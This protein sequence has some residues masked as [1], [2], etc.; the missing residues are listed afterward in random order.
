LA[1]FLAKAY[2]RQKGH[3]YAMFVRF[4][5]TPYGLQVSLIQTRREDGKV[6]YEHI[7]GLGAITIP[8]SP[9][10]RIAFW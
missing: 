8:A 10:D 1:R 6:R 2:G 4:R 7:A 5:E 3:H 9:A